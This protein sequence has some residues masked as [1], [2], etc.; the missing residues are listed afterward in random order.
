MKTII[1]TLSHPITSEVK[2]VGKTIN[3]KRRWYQHTNIKTLKTIS[4]KHLSNWILNL[5][6]ENLNPKMEIIDSA[7]DDTW[8]FLEQYWI[9]QFKTWGFKLCNLTSGGEGFIYNHTDETKLKLSR[10]HKGKSYNVS[11]DELDR[12]RLFFRE[13]NPMFNPVIKNKIITGIKHTRGFTQTK[14]FSELKREH[15]FE[16]IKKG[17][18]PRQRAVLKLDLDYNIIQEYISI[19]ECAHIEKKSVRQ[20]RYLLDNKLVRNMNF[21]LKY[22]NE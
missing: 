18:H 10:S 9:S 19:K 1:Y 11:Q 20:I 5:K 4:N 16:Q 14:E 13:N 15:L 2:Y 12:R 6:K 8:G 22:K 21:S 7:F 3:F 17:K